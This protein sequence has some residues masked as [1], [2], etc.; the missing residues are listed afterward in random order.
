MSWKAVK[1][2]WSRL[3]GPKIWAVQDLETHTWHVVIS[4]G[5]PLDSIYC[6][7][8]L[9]G[10]F[11]SSIDCEQFCDRMNAARR[12]SLPPYDHSSVDDQQQA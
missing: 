5:K 2:W 12:G 1:G 8:H 7:E 10:P 11:R 3:F 6:S 4:W 9:R